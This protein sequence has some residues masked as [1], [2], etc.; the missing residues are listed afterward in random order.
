EQGVTS[1][2]RG[3]CLRCDGGEV[4]PLSRLVSGSITSPRI[5]HGFPR[6]GQRVLRGRVS[7][8]LRI[9]RS[10]PKVCCVNRMRWEH[11]RVSSVHAPAAFHRVHATAEKTSKRN[12]SRDYAF[13]QMARLVVCWNTHWGHT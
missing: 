9:W 6:R 5:R 10:T 7:Y 12:P 13:S 4:S 2:P 8:Q 3:H 1:A 11:R